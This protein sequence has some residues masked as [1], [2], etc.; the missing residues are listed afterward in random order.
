VVVVAW[1]R[2]EGFEASKDRSHPPTTISDLMEPVATIVMNAV[3]DAV[4]HG[5]AEHI[6]LS[7]YLEGDEVVLRVTNDGAELSESSPQG[8]GQA[9][10][11]AWPRVLGSGPCAQE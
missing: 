4:R 2:G 1:C 7:C 8:L 6:G 5:G 9:P 10:S 3:N 11:T